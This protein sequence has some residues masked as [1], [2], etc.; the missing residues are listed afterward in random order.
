[1][2]Q[3]L[4]MMINYFIENI[5]KDIVIITTHEHFYMFDDKEK[6]FDKEL[7]LNTYKNYPVLLR[8]DMPPN[9]EFIIMSK[10][11]FLRN[12]EDWISE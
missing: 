4:N 5:D 9:N 7:K 3:Q 6:G 12:I 1:M 11:D 8:K 2:L 10:E